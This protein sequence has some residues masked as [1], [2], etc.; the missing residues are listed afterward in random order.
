MEKFGFTTN[1]ER[2]VPGTGK[3]YMID[4]MTSDWAVAHPL[5]VDGFIEDVYQKYLMMAEDDPSLKGWVRSREELHRLWIMVLSCKNPAGDASLYPNRDGRQDPACMEVWHLAGD[6]WRRG[7]R[8]GDVLPERCPSFRITRLPDG[9]WIS[10]SPKDLHL[11]TDAQPA[12]LLQT[13]SCEHVA[14]SEQ[15]ADDCE[16]EPVYSDPIAEII[17]EAVQEDPV[18]LQSS[19]TGSVLRQAQ[20]P[21]LVGE[22]VEPQGPLEQPTEQPKRAKRPARRKRVLLASPSVASDHRSSATAQ[23]PCALSGS[24]AGSETVSNDERMRKVIA[25]VGA[26]AITLL[27]IHFFGLLGPAV[28]GLLAGGILKG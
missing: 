1:I 11:L 16:H 2:R 25:F 17:S 6:Y 4:R 27:M 20:E 12:V 8:Y 28:F 10:L 13:R 19:A 5:D 14:A 9:G 15:C 3:V 24:S 7:L 26:V 23:E 21:Y 18:V 22:L